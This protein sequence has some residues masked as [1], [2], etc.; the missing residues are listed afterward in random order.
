MVE[1]ET[2][3]NSLFNKLE[4]KLNFRVS[5]EAKHFVATLIKE[6]LINHRA[7]HS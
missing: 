4:K 3:P 1:L 2:H 5:T 6:E 7:V